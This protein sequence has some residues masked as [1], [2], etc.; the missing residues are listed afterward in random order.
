MNAVGW[1]G[2]YVFYPEYTFNGLLLRRLHHEVF[3]GNEACIAKYHERG[4]YEI[5]W[6]GSR[7]YLE[8]VDGLVERARAP[9]DPRVFTPVL[10]NLQ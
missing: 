7:V 3:T 2:I 10:W 5:V 1:E 4:W 8:Q 9:Y 6:K